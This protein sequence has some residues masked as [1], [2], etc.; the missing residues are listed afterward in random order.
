MLHQQDP[1]VMDDAAQITQ[2]TERLRAVFGVTVCFVTSDDVTKTKPDPEGVY[3]ALE[4]LGLGRE[5]TEGVVMVGDHHVD[6]LAGKAGGTLT[7]RLTHGFGKP[8]ELRDAGATALCDSLG[9]LRGV[10]GL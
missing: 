2:L 6:V 10:L 8:G 9:E 5:D 1:A 4:K 7:V 3:A